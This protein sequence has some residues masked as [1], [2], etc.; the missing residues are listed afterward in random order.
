MNESTLLEY[1]EKL[2]P[3]VSGDFQKELL[4]ACLK[5][6]GDE[7]NKLR[8][9]NFAYSIRELSR[10]FLTTL[11]PDDEITRCDWY[12]NTTNEVGKM[13]RRERIKYS[14]QGGLSDD[15]LENEFFNIDNFTK[16]VLNSIDMLNKYTHVSE[17]TFGL[18]N[19]EVVQLS[20][21]IVNT[22]DQLV[23]GIKSCKEQIV[24]QLDA[25]VDETIVEHTLFESIDEIDIISTH[26]NV[27]EM[28]YSMI[29]VED[30]KSRFI[31]IGVSG[32]LK[33]RQQFGSNGDLDKGDG[34]EL[35]NS[36]P[37]ES[38]LSQELLED[39]PKTDMNVES[40]VVNTDDWYK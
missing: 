35:Y 37:F 27:E 28:E 22:F 9:N 3:L 7:S 11:A 40:F 6:L 26:Y 34:L 17:E 32:M 4:K 30:I 20:K 14:I 23:V 19:N 36:Y 16:P 18:A 24:R 38:K 13:S 12:K 15:Y 33:V 5:N 39:F 25:N 31:I 1:F 10:H 29:K 2:E 21:Q 8:F